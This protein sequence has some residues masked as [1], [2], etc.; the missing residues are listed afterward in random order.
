VRPLLAVLA[1]IG[2]ALLAG[3]C[4]QGSSQTAW[5]G[6]VKKHNAVFNTRDS[7]NAKAYATFKQIAAQAPPEIRADFA[8]M[9][10][11]A[12]HVARKDYK[13]LLPPYITQWRSAVS[14]VDSYLQKECGVN[15]PGRG[16]SS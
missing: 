10:N 12:A 4:S 5:C 6:V 16:S 15:P 14:H 7:N 2:I 13:Y 1:A 3:G 11:E 8:T 9:F